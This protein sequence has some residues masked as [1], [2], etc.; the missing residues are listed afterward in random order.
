MLKIYN[1]ILFTGG[2]YQHRKENGGPSK[3]SEKVKPVEKEREMG[4]TIV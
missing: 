4:I 1:Q 3:S 2:K